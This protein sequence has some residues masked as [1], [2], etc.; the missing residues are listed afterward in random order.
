LDKLTCTV[1]EGAALL[2]ISR[3]KMY[4]IVH[5]DSCT[6]AI[7]IGRRILISRAALEKWIM[8]Q[9]VAGK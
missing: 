9:T 6:F 7:R 3:P 2:G 4:E 8:D 1:D 5:S